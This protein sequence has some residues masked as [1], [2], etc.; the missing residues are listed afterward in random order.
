MSKE[1]YKSIQQIELILFLKGYKL[2]S[3]FVSKYLLI[4]LKIAYKVHNF[5]YYEYNTVKGI[6]LYYPLSKI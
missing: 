5:S 4:F 3:I 2:F 6:Y 1:F